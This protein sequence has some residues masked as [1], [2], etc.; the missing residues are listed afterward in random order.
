MKSRFFPSLFFGLAAL[1]LA[2]LPLRAQRSGYA[3]V[4][5]VD[6][7]GSILSDANGRTEIQ[8]NLPLA[9]GD[10][11][12]TDA[13]AHAEIE[14]A[15]GNRVQIAGESRLRLDA[16]AGEQG[17]N[18]DESAI[19]LLEGSAAAESASFDDARAFR[20]DTADASAYVTAKGR[21]RVNLDANRGT[22]V[23][24]RA[25]SVD[26]QT[27]SG[28]ITAEAGQYVLVHGDEQPELAR[29]SFS[30]D[31]FDV[32]V[33]DRTETALSAYNSVSARYVDG[34]EYDQDV[35]AL[36]DYGSWDYS[37]TYDTEVWR[38][39]VGA[40][41]SPYS[42]GYWYYTPVG[43]SWVPYEPWGWFPHHF[44]NW[45]F[46][47]GFGSWCWS[48][49]FVYSPGWV[50]WGFTNGFVGWCPIGSYAYYGPYAN[51]WGGYGGWHSG[52]YFSVSGLFDSGRV[53]WHHGWNFVDSHHFGSHFDHRSVLPGS[54]VASRLGARVAITSDP[55]R[56]PIVTGRG[57]AATAL[58][59]YVRTAP[60]TIARQSSPER[61]AALTPFLGR[62]AK[63]PAA[64][65]RTLQDTQLARVNPSARRLEGPGA[66]RLVASPRQTAGSLSGS[67]SLSG[68]A[69][70]N[71]GQARTESWRAPQ[72]NSFGSS[73]RAVPPPSSRSG[74][75]SNDWRRPSSIS[76]RSIAPR[77][78]SGGESWRERPA[79]PRGYASTPRSRNSGGAPAES[80]RT[81]AN[82]PPA[83]RV[84]EGID[85]GRA[86]PPPRS[87][88]YVRSLPER[89]SGNFEPREIAPM[90]RYQRS[91]PPAYGL[92]ESAPPSRSERFA[93]P[94]A[95]RAEPSPRYSAAPP[96][97]ERSAPPP[98]SAPP[99]TRE[100][101]A[102]APAPRSSPPPPPR[103]GEYRPP[104][105]RS[106]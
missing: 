43:A 50:Y 101:R 96:R 106:H 54:A 100:Y 22:T 57:S 78:P 51:Y 92:R 74:E 89:R 93:P 11:I 81:R 104:H 77:S 34:D 46:D 73:S 76:P 60:A 83:Q 102:P 52:L 75:R 9:E 98:R 64:T 95:R 65:V 85:R 5:D 2:A 41:W 15:D 12:V 7:A 35:A 62:Q 18:A 66:D 48:P 55:V 29:G 72:R 20:I 84:I 19:T 28:S 80:W 86:V 10:T 91:A 8:V 17:S 61:S 97:Y 71:P 40:D 44:G 69:F 39:N 88:P 25:G 59:S 31:R 63:L 32:W 6:G 70:R 68:G 38:P 82:T 13:G 99:Q 79:P 49:A 36:D 26:V 24:V 53:D 94:D 58:R 16:L 90:P 103:G 67:R 42:D 56:V 37:P 1:F 45:F 47:A 27:R 33:A 105:G 3:H 30:R 21:A 23:I 14:L 87:E 4:T